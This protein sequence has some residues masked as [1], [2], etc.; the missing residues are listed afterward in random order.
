MAQA[1]L[2]NKYYESLWMHKDIIDVE[3]KAGRDNSTY[4][5]QQFYN[6]VYVVY[7]LLQK[8]FPECKHREGRCECTWALNM[9]FKWIFE[10]EREVA[11]KINNDW[12]TCFYF[13]DD[14]W[15]STMLKK[16]HVTY[17]LHVLQNTQI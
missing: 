4:I 13:C 3:M 12:I 15:I 1:L 5:S 2:D 17:I 14:C 10:L 16:Y 8:D 6:L 7:K 11:K 9:T